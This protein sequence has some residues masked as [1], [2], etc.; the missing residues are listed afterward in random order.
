LDEY[1]ARCVLENREPEFTPEKAK[2][3]IAGVLM[4]YLSA[5]TG[6]TATRDDLMEVAANRGTRSLLES[7]TEHI[8]TSKNLP[9]VKNA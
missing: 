9:E 6:K 3:A 8:P 4:G 2:S 5:Q 7:L 1:F